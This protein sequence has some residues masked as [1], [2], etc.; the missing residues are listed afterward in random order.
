MIVGVLSAVER[1]LAALLRLAW[2]ITGRHGK[3]PC[4]T[5]AEQGA[6]LRPVHTVWPGYGI[7]F[8]W[9]LGW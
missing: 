1:L 6:L 7:L 3:A 5:Q 2:G 4:A 8:F 9:K